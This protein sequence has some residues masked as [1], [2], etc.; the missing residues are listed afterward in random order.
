MFIAEQAVQV[1][2]MDNGFWFAMASNEIANNNT[3]NVPEQIWEQTMYDLDRSYCG[4]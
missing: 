4:V 1:D 2:E 3:F